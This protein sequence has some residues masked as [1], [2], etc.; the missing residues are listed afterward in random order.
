MLELLA[1]SKA[2]YGCI[3]RDSEGGFIAGRSAVKVSSVLIPSIAEALSFREALSWL[4]SLHFSSVIVESDAV[5]VVNALKN[6]LINDSCFALII[7]DCISLVKEIS[8]C[9][10]VDVRQSANQVAHSLARASVF[11]G[12]DFLHPLTLF[13]M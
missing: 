13:V 5:S 11:V 7:T 8:G 10:V 12:C 9:S 4:K 6:N 1:L 3:I 2:G